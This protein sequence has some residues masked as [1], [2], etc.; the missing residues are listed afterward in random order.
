M[1]SSPKLV[2]CSCS[3]GDRRQRSR[4]GLSGNASSANIIRW[5][6][7]GPASCDASPIISQRIVLA[8]GDKSPAVLR[9]WDHLQI[10]ADNHREDQCLVEIGLVH[11]ALAQRWPAAGDAWPTINRRCS[12]VACLVQI[13]VDMQCEHV[14]AHRLCVCCAETNSSNCLLSQESS[15][16]VCICMITYHGLL[17]PS[18]TSTQ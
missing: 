17:S 8:A 18:G 1:S 13:W 2:R 6:I 11:R 16:C 15:Y 3:D 4:C 5:L 10:I 9:E 12:D 7:I 14:R